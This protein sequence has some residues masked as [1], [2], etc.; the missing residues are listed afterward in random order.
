MNATT[1]AIRLSITIGLIIVLSLS[2]HWWP[3]TNSHYAKRFWPNILL[4]GLA[5]LSLQLFFFVGGIAASL[6]ALKHH[7]GLFHYIWMPSIPIYLLSV[8]ILDIGIYWQH[9][10]MHRFPLLWTL[11]QVH[12]ADTSLDL[13][14]GIRFHPFEALLSM[15][16]RSLLI[17][18]FGIPTTAVILFEI[19]LNACSLFNHSN[20]C[21]NHTL[22]KYLRLIIVTPDMHRIH[23]STNENDQHHNFGFNLSVWDRVFHSYKKSS[24]MPGIGL[25]YLNDKCISLTKML[26]LP[27]TKRRNANE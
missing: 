6:F 12:H 17:L 26:L 9:V 24:H 23:H 27:F 20:I 3:K 4:G 18:L 7:L 16:Y 25:S 1:N 2:E 8:I 14:T 15:L 13:S 19:I 11:H 10:A 21:L 22:D 5:A